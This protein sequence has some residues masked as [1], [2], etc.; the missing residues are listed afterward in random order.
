[1]AKAFLAEI[2][3]TANSITSERSQDC[4]ICLER[5]GTLSLETGITELEVRLPCSHIVGS[6]V[7]HHPRILN[8]GFCANALIYSALQP[9]SRGTI[10]VHYVGTSSSHVNHVHTWSMK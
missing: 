2:L 3:T 5:C 8:C 1:M 4:V 6:A 7:S 9:G 10:L